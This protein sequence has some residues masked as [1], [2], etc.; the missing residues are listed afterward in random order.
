MPIASS[1]VLALAL[2]KESVF[3]RVVPPSLRSQRGRL[4]GLS[5]QREW[6]VTTN[7]LSLRLRLFLCDLTHEYAVIVLTA[8]WREKLYIGSCGS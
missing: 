7:N 6:Q 3:C 1:E 8:K 5:V 4:K 2:A